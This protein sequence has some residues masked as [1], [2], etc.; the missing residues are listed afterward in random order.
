MKN[1]PLIFTGIG[2]FTILF[3]AY[4]GGSKYYDN[5]FLPNTLMG[6]IELSGL[7]IDEAKRVI[8]QDLHTN[9]VTV[10]EDEETV[11]TFTPYDLDAKV[12]SD[13]FL[14]KVKNEQNNW[15]WPIAFFKGE[16]VETSEIAVQFDEAALA[17]L[18][19]TLTLSKAERISP[20]SANVQSKNG[21]FVIEPEVPGNIIDADLLEE[22]LVQTM[23]SSEDSVALEDAYVL[24]ALTAESDELKQV[25]EKL[26]GLTDVTITYSL[27]GEEIVVPKEQ[28]ATWLSLDNNGEPTVDIEAAKTYLQT[29]HDKYATYEK[30]RTFKSTNRGEVQVPPGEY[31]WS[32]AIE[33]ESKN[34]AS[35]ILAGKDIKTTP[36]ILGS[37]YHEDGTDIGS[38]Y[39][40]VDLQNQM[41]YYYKN[42]E[43]L[44]ETPIVSGHTT[45]PT[46][47]GVFYAWNKEE[48]A[49]L[50]G[51]NP[52]R[53]NDYAQ[54]VNYW[55]PVD[56]T[57]VGIHDAGWQTS[58]SS[59]QWVNNGSN[60]CIN[61]PPGAMEK[62]FSLM[63]VGT[64]VIFF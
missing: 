36:E 56:W 48:D 51:Y 60:G 12:E 57:G 2:I 52:R 29:L 40:E 13:A 19:E 46:P 61:T 34:L 39:I 25:V 26:Q 11:T 18:V 33:A 20:V 1:K 64:P 54:P 6:E 28:L 45:T 35:Y 55:I 21:T 44:L 37:G 14:K 7:T 50:I 53:G 63:D 10:T 41:M 58:F 16:K 22:Q 30:T 38:T 4:F 5:R 62:L 17:K 3:L 32:I 59:D 24:P 47:V 8:T 23:V 15:T 27:G 43:R 49:E 42:G 31:G 9:T